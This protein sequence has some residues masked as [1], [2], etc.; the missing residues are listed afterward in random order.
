MPIYRTQ[1]RNGDE[2]SINKYTVSNDLEGADIGER[3]MALRKDFV[4]QREELLALQKEWGRDPNWGRFLKHEANDRLKLY[5]AACLLIPYVVTEPPGDCPWRP[6]WDFPPELWAPL[7]MVS[8][9]AGSSNI[10]YGSD[11][12]HPIEKDTNDEDASVSAV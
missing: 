7:D 9:M 6:S 12:L 1:P 2:G 8:A 3:L 11:G 5:R 10:G 4:V